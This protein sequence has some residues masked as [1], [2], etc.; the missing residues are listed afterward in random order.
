MNEDKDFDVNVYTPKLTDIENNVEFAIAR[1]ST[2]HTEDEKHNILTSILL[3]LLSILRYDIAKEKNKIRK[4]TGVPFDSDTDDRD[5][6]E[7]KEWLREKEKNYKT[8]ENIAFPDKVEDLKIIQQTV[9][10]GGS[11][12][13]VRDLRSNI[14]IPARIDNLSSAY[15][16]KEWIRKVRTDNELCRIIIMA[17]S[18]AMEFGHFQPEAKMGATPYMGYLSGMENFHTRDIREVKGEDE[19]ENG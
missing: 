19:E 14:D 10:G 9:A 15:K 7:R 17:K 12:Y 13:V 5:I 6:E 18:D 4:K 1:L 2:A 3:D 11:G 16:M 8:Y